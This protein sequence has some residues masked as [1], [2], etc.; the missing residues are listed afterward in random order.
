MHKS[1]NISMASDHA[2]FPLKES[3]KAYLE[4]AGYA[5]I[6]F[7]AWS[8]KPVDYPE[9]IR[10]AAQSVAGGEAVVGI[11]VGGTG[12][13]EAMAANKI[14]GI[15]CAVCWDGESAKLAKEH[16]NANMIALGARM[17]SSAEAFRIVDTWLHARFRG[18]RHQRRIEQIEFG[19]NEREEAR[20]RGFRRVLAGSLV[21]VFLVGLMACS[22]PA[23][24]SP[25]GVLDDAGIS[26]RVKTR[27]FAD[28]R[29]SGFAIGVNT[30]KGEVTLSG[31]VD[32]QEQ[33]ELATQIAQS[34]E[35]VSG[36]NNVIMLKR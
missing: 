25:G 11:V 16:N 28:D 31:G 7:G 6:D 35:G 27:L 8:E 17:M 22:T 12:N 30:F 32:T 24:R 20:M 9:Y 18:G 23:G 21:L 13:G 1:I 5:V 2:G 14:R 15:R 19:R 34:V 10:R 33:K 36:V 29:L 26:T 4:S 3:V